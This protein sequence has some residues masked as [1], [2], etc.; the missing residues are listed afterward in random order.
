MCE[1]LKLISISKIYQQ[2]KTTGDK[3]TTSINDT[4][5]VT[6]IKP[7]FIKNTLPPRSQQI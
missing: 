2:L 3:P 6:P 4:N 5:T 1:V 7:C